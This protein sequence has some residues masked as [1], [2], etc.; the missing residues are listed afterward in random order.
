[1]INIS[2]RGSFSKAL[3]SGE[4]Q[5]RMGRTRGRAVGAARGGGA[6]AEG[7]TTTLLGRYLEWK[8]RRALQAAKVEQTSRGGG[9]GSY[10]A[11]ATSSSSSSS[12][13]SSSSIRLPLFLN[14]I[15][16][17]IAQAAAGTLCVVGR[18]R[19]LPLL[20]LA[21]VPRRLSQTL[22]PST[23]GTSIYYLLFITIIDLNVYLFN[24]GRRRTRALW[25]CASWAQDQAGRPVP[26]TWPK[27]ATGSA[28]LK[29]TGCLSSGC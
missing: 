27:P 13:P 20:A 19:P 18:W 10:F 7:T 17:A 1:M 14:R 26:T 28:A 2:F 11:A 3:A 25:T 4:E 8:K 24:G 6:R 9:V 12:S 23:R 16:E 15:R 21:V 5:E 29:D 22:H